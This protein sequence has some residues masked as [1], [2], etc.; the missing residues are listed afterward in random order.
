MNLENMKPV[1]QASHKRHTQC[2]SSNMRSLEEPKSQRQRV[3]GW[4]W[5]A[6]AGG[7]QCLMGAAPVL[8]EE[9][10]GWMAGMLTWHRECTWCHWTGPL[11][12]GHFIC[13]SPL[14]KES[15][16]GKEATA[17]GAWDLWLW[18][19]AR[20]GGAGWDQW[21]R[22]PLLGCHWPNG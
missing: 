8:Q 5:G 11:K 18:W 15:K 6:R 21:P 10:C 12:A 16:P 3:G 22:R 1:K 9:F 14:K 19:A 17:M 4:L 7:G 13:I 2:D 20:R